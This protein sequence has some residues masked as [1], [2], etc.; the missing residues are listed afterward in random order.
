MKLTIEDSPLWRFKLRYQFSGWL[1]YIVSTVATLLMLLL[2]G[3]GTLIGIW[4]TLLIWLPL[5]LAAVFFT[6]LVTNIATVKFGLHPPESLPKPRTSLNA[7]DLM[8]TRRSCRSFQRCQLTLE[9]RGSLLKLATLYS[10]EDHQLGQRPIRFEYVAA[11]LKVWPVVGAHEFLV[12][13]A[14]RS[15]D[16]LAVIDVG[17]SLQN[18]VV[19][20]TRM[21]LATCWIGPGADQ[22]SIVEH[23]GDSFS[24]D[25]DHVICVCAIGYQ[26]RYKPLAIRLIKKLQHQRLPLSE[27]FFADARLA[28]PLDTTADPFNRFE[29][30]YEVCQWAPSS[31]NSQTTR[32]VAVTERVDG[33]L[34]LM[35]FDF[36]TAT[37]SRY[38]APVALGIWCAN[39]ETG[40]NHLGLAGHFTVLPS[41]SS[42]MAD[43]PVP[44]YDISWIIDQ[45]A[46]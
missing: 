18:V 2:A 35:R 27:L 3:I 8:R 38:Y 20:A 14:P 21:G 37:A 23:L 45:R 1:Q 33:E 28:T 19:K 44:R 26:S 22:Q 46:E 5:G 43:G 24:P 32:C 17:R 39:W 34:R 11:P 6:I 9:H 29:R 25:N 7:F 30:C 31:Y 41:E 42:R 10:R 15:Y 40:C 36:Y 12:A 16:R 13:I 4:P